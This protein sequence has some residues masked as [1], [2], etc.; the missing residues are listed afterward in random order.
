MKINTRVCRQV[1]AGSILAAIVSSLA[2]AGED[3][4]GSYAIALWGDL[5]YSDLQATAGVPNLIA[6]MNAQ[7]L[8]F[9]VHDGDL[10]AGNG[11]VGSVT[12]TTCED[13]LYVQGLT[14]FNSLKAPAIF[15]PGDNGPTV[16]VRRTADFRRSND[17]NTNAWF[18]STPRSR[19]AV[20][21]S[22]KRCRLRRT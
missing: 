13:A 5:P 7:D 19:W 8:A 3:D 16:T 12:P 6:D 11:T 14:F 2:T 10:K 20:I 15:T 1:L 17:W 18:S 9:S 4:R 21:G 22:S